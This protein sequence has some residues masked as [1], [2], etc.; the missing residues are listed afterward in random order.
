MI[1]SQ[2]DTMIKNVGRSTFIKSEQVKYLTERVRLNKMIYG[3]GTTSSEAWK[4]NKYDDAFLEVFTQG[5]LNKW[6]GLYLSK[7]KQLDYRYDRLLE[8]TL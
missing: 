2:V 3:I 5:E 7:R 4:S 8:M 6:Q 1:Q